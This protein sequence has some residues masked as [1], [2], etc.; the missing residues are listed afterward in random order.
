MRR[1]FD[2]IEQL[3]NV[4]ERRAGPAR[5]ELACVDAKRPSRAGRCCR[6]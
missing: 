3:G 6:R 4:V 2:A 5:A 1:T